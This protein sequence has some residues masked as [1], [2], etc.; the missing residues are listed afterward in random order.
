[1]LLAADDWIELARA[2]GLGEV[3]A[4]GVDGRGL[5]GPLGLLRRPDRARLR[6]DADD[7]MTDLVEV[8]AE[9]L[10]DAGG[11]ALALA[12]E[13]EQQVLRADVVVVEPLRLVLR[14]CQDLARAVGEFV[15]PLHGVE[16]PFPFCAVVAPRF[17]LA[18][19]P[20][21]SGAAGAVGEPHPVSRAMRRN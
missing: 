2:G 7:L 8:D 9:G 19:A 10:E 17:M 18:R 11:D 3:D 1:L 4:E 20:R 12:D 6:Q 5:R 21:E 16:R 14:Q 15:E 13:A